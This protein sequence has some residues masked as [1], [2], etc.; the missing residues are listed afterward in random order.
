MEKNLEIPPEVP[1]NAAETP[2]IGECC[3]VRAAAKLL[4]IPHTTVAWRVRAGK[5]PTYRDA[6]GRVVV[7]LEDA[8][9]SEP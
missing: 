3:S 6:G 4:G 7:R 9:R 1:Q 2:A 5:I 8:R